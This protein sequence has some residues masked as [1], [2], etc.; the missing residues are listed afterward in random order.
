MNFALATR[1]YEQQQFA[2]AL[3]SV[4][5]ALRLKEDDHR[6]YA[7]RGAAQVALGKARDATLSFERA[8]E[9]QKAEE[10]RAQSR[11]AFGG[12]ALQ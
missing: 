12:L 10:L 7:L 2:E 1:A 6:F 3:A 5:K 8:R 9:Y 4:R 11:V